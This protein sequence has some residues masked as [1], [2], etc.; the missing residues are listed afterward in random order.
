MFLKCKLKPGQDRQPLHGL[1]RLDMLGRLFEEL[2]K[3]KYK[4]SGGKRRTLR[5]D[6]AVHMSN[7][8]FVF[9]FSLISS[10]D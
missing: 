1:V 8:L 7:V 2:A 5:D 6:S 3:D 10:L 9:V 4:P